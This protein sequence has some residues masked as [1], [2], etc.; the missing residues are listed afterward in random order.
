MDALQQP[1]RISDSESGRAMG[2]LASCVPWPVRVRNTVALQI[3]ARDQAPDAMPMSY[4]LKTITFC[5]CSVTFH[6]S[7]VGS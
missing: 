1:T 5:R 7:K 6:D 2:S 3:V 4:A